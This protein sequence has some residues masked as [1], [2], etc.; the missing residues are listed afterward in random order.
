[1]FART[2]ALKA[3]DYFNPRFPYIADYDTWL[4]MARLFPLHYTPEVL[5]K[6]RV[7]DMQFTHRCPD[8]TL[9]DHRR[10][11]GELYRTASIPRPIR[12]R[13][14]DRLLGQHRVSARLLVKQGRYFEAGRALAGMCSYPDRLAAY[15]IGA[16]AETPYVGEALRRGYRWIRSKATAPD[17][18]GRGCAQK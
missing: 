6:W 13:L 5:A 10:L 7:Y 11:L 4:Q 14:G 1:V 3:V 15:G 17:L 2:E 16:V 12:I 18:H 8:V 9:A